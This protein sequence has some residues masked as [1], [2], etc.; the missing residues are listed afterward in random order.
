MDDIGVM[1]GEAETAPSP[2][3]RVAPSGP[4]LQHHSGWRI[5]LLAHQPELSF[6][7]GAPQHNLLRRAACT[8]I[9]WQTGLPP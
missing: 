1:G 9:S 4:R 6:G 2:R 8:H 3:L 7:G 5:V